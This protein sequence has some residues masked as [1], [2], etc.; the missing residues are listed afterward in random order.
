[1]IVSC[2]HCGADFQRKPSAVKKRS[3]QYCSLDCYKQ[4]TMKRISKCELCG[5]ETGNMRFCSSACWY[6]YNR[7]QTETVE[8]ICPICG[9]ASMVAE[10]KFRYT[11]GHACCSKECGW[12]RERRRL[13]K[14]CEECG[15][16]FESHISAKRK[17]CSRECATAGLRKQVSVECA[18]CG[19]TV[20]KTPSLIARVGRVYCGLPCARAHIRGENAAV[21]KGGVSNKLRRLRSSASFKEWR[22][23]VFER[24]DYTCQDCGRRGAE[25]H[26]HHIKAFADYPKLRFDVSN[27][28]TLCLLC[29]GKIHGIT[30][31]RRKARTHSGEIPRS[32]L[33]KIVGER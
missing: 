32:A 3:K 19:D 4:D 30:Y 24:D 21:W 9:K 15:I 16:E 29:H 27:G 31:A 8:N 10:S 2:H 33:E 25:L 14:S 18:N 11:N 20:I 5:K 6:E 22:T 23:A 13:V 26:P 17:Y 7:L 12:I 28:I 1:M